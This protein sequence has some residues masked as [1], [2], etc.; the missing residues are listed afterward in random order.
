MLAILDKIQGLWPKANEDEI[1]LLN[2]ILDGIEESKAVKILKDA[3]AESSYATIPFKG[4][5]AKAAKT[6]KQGGLP[7]S[8]IECWAV[9]KDTKKFKNCC[10]RAGDSYGAKVMMGNYLRHRCN[11]EPT[12]YVIFVGKDNFRAFWDYRMGKPEVVAEETF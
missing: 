4:I 9:H 11:V 2:E 5:T 10:V 12:D 6:G 8:Y 7:G 3:R 1:Q